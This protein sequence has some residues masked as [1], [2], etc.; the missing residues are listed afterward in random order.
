MNAPGD[1][2][3]M[4]P[5]VA[6]MA[7][8]AHH[9]LL[10]GR[11]RVWLTLFLLITLPSPAAAPPGD[12][13]AAMRL[14][15]Q[16]QVFC[17]LVD[18]AGLTPRLS[19]PGPVT[20]FAP[21]DAAF[22]RLGDA[23]RDRLEHTANRD[24]LRALLLYH[25][26]PGRIDVFRLRRE[27]PRSTMHGKTITSLLMSGAMMVNDAFIDIEDIPAANGLVHGIDKVLTL[28]E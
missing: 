3:E 18:L 8:R 27:T 1:N 10:R 9:A 6:A 24:E 21:T 13:L 20:V 5:P 19:G 22:H 2:P 28:P 16:F 14:W 11:R 15:G 25:V 23:A 26:V 12:V 17:R 7:L 4:R